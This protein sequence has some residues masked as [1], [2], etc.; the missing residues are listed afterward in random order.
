MYCL[1]C[2]TESPPGLRFCNRCGASLKEHVHSNPRLIRSFLLAVV[3]VGLSG[4]G[5]MLGGGL[6]LKT[7]GNMTQDIV[8]IFM[9]FT[10]LLTL[11]I[12]IFLMRQLSKLL[13]SPEKHTHQQSDRFGPTELRVPLTRTLPEPALSVTENTT[14]T[15]KYARSEQQR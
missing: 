15:L 9:M 12:E 11:I 1:A 8:A 10:F 2:G 5:I 14:R 4:L 7:E 3:I 13:A 6:K